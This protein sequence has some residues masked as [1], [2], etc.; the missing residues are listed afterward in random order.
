MT[1]WLTEHLTLETS[2]CDT[3][4]NVHEFRL[5]HMLGTMETPTQKRCVCV[6]VFHL[7]V[8]TYKVNCTYLINFFL[9]VYEGTH[10]IKTYTQLV[11]C[12][13]GSWL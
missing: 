9:Q 6:C 12:F 1:S 7:Q 11:Y 5:R 2:G 8:T 10:R 13:N 4:Q 3:C